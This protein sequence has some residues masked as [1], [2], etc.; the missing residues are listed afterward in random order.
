[1]KLSVAFVGLA[2]VTGA[3]QAQT[4]S[5]TKTTD[6][7]A[8]APATVTTA[9]PGAKPDIKAK[10]E[11]KKKEEAM[12]TI[13]GTEIK[14]AN[15]TYLGLEVVGGHFVLSFY[16]AKKK[17]MAVDVTRANARWPNK[18]SGTPS[19]YRTVLNGSGTTLVGE[20]PVLPPLTFTVRLNL[21]QGE[22]DASKVVESFVVPFQ[23]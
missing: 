15:G 22:G 23:G 9:K 11:P 16:N 8:T 10:V 13:K 7:K 12:G 19:E 2:L 14:R 21:L 6:P 18:R 3:L 1:M 20:G 5:T 17:P 4:P